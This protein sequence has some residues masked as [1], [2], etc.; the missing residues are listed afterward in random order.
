MKVFISD[1]TLFIVL[2]SLY[3]F[4]CFQFGQI[5]IKFEIEYGVTLGV[6]SRCPPKMAENSVISQ[7]GKTLHSLPIRALLSHRTD[8]NKIWALKS[9]TLTRARYHISHNRPPHT[10]C[11]NVFWHKQSAQEWCQGLVTR[12]R[13][14]RGSTR[15]TADGGVVLGELLPGAFPRNRDWCGPEFEGHLAPWGR[16]GKKS[17]EV[18]SMY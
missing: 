15:V 18:A 1:L 5:T 12:H 16:F 11:C 2:K 13:G 17:Q 3:G 8:T 9:C 14:P 10:R 4:R 6:V 7:Q